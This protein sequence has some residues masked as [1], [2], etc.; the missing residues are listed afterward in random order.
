MDSAGFHAVILMLMVTFCNVFVWIG[1]I[2]AMAS[3]SCSCHGRNRQPV[4]AGYWPSSANSY[5]PPWN[6]NASLYTH[7]FYAFADLDEE[8]F[9]VT[10]APED[11][12]ILEGFSG[13]VQEINSSVKTLISIG[14]GGSNATLYSIMAANSTYMKSFI[15]SSIALAR[16]HEFHGLDLDWVFPENSADMINLGLLLA[17]WRGRVHEESMNTGLDP[18]L[19][20]AGVYFSEQ[21]FDGEIRGYPIQA[22]ADNLDWINVMCFDYHGP[23]DTTQTGAQAALYDLRSHLSTSYGIGSW[24]DAGIPDY[25]VVMGMPM[26]GRS[27]TL[28]NKKKVTIGAPAVAAGPRQNL[29]DQA[30]FMMF[31]E[32]QDFIVK[33]NATV[34][35]D[36]TTVSAYCYGG[37][38]WIAYDNE[39]TVSMKTMFAKDRGLLGYFFWAISYDHNWTLSKQASKTWNEYCEYG[40][41]RNHGDI[42][43]VFSAAPAS[44]PSPS[45]QLL[46]GPSVD[47]AVPGSGKSCRD[48]L[49]SL[50]VLHLLL[51]ARIL[52]LLA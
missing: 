8:T 1:G 22:M 14:G 18:L 13:T 20:T 25:K 7:M 31:N 12:Q 50:N 38:V 2:Q 26:Y 16:Q 5:M 35:V 52:L 46:P 29:S 24:L 45:T 44:S 6:I 30:G 40:G 43:E 15:D 32:I 47:D 4:K 36:N 33:N 21:F 9:T 23:W 42:G 28:R 48:S 3:S 41:Q 11:E 37:D 10:V 51:L 39:E 49:G 27:W 34:V 17:Q 19:L